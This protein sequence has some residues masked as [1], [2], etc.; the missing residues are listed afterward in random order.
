MLLTDRM[1]AAAHHD[2]SFS[3]Q[4]IKRLA[5]LETFFSRA[6]QGS[7]LIATVTATATATAIAYSRNDRV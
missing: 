1:H 4:A 7:Y 5:F 6:S 3:R 2:R